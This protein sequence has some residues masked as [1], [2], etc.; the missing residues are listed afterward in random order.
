MMSYSGLYPCQN[1][2]KLADMCIPFEIDIP[3]SIYG[4][5][6]AP[7][8]VNSVLLKIHD[9]IYDLVLS[10]QLPSKTSNQ[11]HMFSLEIDIFKANYY[12]NGRLI[13]GITL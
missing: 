5:P 1:I 10:L 2:Y 6:G 9:I 8:Y 11:Q 13:P 7:S 12:P 4:G 3:Q